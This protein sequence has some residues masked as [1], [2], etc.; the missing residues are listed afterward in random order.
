MVNIHSRRLT[1]K[2]ADS[3]KY[4]I[5]IAHLTV[6]VHYNNSKNNIELQGFTFS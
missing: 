1:K 5:S 6:K 2:I 4:I 3:L